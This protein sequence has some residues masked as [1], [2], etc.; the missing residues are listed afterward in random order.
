M[1]DLFLKSLARLLREGDKNEVVYMSSLMEDLTIIYYTANTEN[2]IFEQRII[3][4]LKEQAGN[5]PIISV[6]RKPIDLGKNICIGEQPVCY[7]NSWKQLLIGLKEAKTK[8]CI[9]AESDVLYPPEYFK[10]IPPTED[11]VYRYTNVWVCF[12]GKAGLWRKPWSEGAQICGRKYWIERLENA[13]GNNDGWEPMSDTLN[14]SK[15]IFS[16]RDK[17]SWTGNPAI[18]FKTRHGINY[19]TGFYHGRVKSLPYWGTIKSIY[20]RMFG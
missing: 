19:K 5:I 13:L 11:N 9:A 12:Y 16:T 8:F 6:S 4:N 3:N 17:Y 20:K 18:T 1:L 14:I 7:S 10:F 2:T 15:R